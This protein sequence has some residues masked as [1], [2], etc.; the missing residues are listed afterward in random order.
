M[1]RPIMLRP[2]ADAAGL[3][4]AF[5]VEAERVPARL[6]GR[7]VEPEL[8]AEAPQLVASDAAAG[9]LFFE[10]PTFQKTIA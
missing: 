8:R 1:A 7:L 9:A 2:E 3:V 4:L 10:K 5:V 6:G